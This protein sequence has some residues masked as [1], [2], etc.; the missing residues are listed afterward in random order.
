[1]QFPAELA[2]IGDAQRAQ[3]DTRHRDLAHM[4]EGE[5]G[6]RNIGLCRGGQHV[7]RA[8]AHQRQRAP[9][10]R[11]VPEAHTRAI[12][13]VVA[14]PGQVMGAEAGAGDDI[15][16]FI[17]QAR[18]GEVRLDA[19]ARVEEL[20]VGETARRLR[21]M[22]RADPFQ[23]GC[24]IRT[25]EFVLGEARLVED[26]NRLTHMG[27]LLA[28][29]R[30]PVLPAHGIDVARFDARGREPVGALPAQL[31]AEDGTFRLQPLIE[32]R[33]DARAA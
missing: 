28:H 15:E 1:M 32:R 25:R 4:A 9:M 22:G 13:Q 23:R 8:R 7:P 31:G 26:A 20:G 19:A 3:H 2:H 33:D 24:G 17:R 29:M 27:M 16:Q 18:H 21:H 10:L 30:K 12:G 11:H 14:D 6:V 5:G